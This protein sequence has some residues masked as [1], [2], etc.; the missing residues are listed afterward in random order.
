MTLIESA[1]KYLKLLEYW[2]ETEN[3][4]K[5]THGTVKIKIFSNNCGLGKTSVMGVQNTAFGLY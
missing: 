1:Q 2:A 5:N 4:S 3:V